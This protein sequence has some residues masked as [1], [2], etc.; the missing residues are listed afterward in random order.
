MKNRI[1]AIVGLA[2]LAAVPAFAQNIPTVR[3]NVPFAFRAGE[4]HLPAGTYRISEKDPGVVDLRGEN[5]NAGAFLLTHPATAKTASTKPYVLFDQIGDRY[6][7]AGVWSA[8]SKEGAHCFPTRHEKEAL[9]SVNQ[10]SGTTIA[11]NTIPAR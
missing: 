9:Q 4:K 8:G 2:L 6:F 10:T 11:L 1:F 5:S 7:L 3:V